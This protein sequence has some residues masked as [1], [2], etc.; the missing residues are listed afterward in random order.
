MQEYNSFIVWIDYIYWWVYIYLFLA[1]Y[2]SRHQILTIE[3]T[4]I[5]TFS[6]SVVLSVKFFYLMGSIMGFA[7][8]KFEM[9]WSK[10]NGIFNASIVLF[11]IF[12]WLILVQN[13]GMEYLKIFQMGRI[14]HQF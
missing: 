2:N 14:A 1:F 12:K 4:E 8:L 3:L 13:R 5:Q 9:F 10:S 7:K 6:F 11:H